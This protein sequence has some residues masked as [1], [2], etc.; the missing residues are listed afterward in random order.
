LTFGRNVFSDNPLI[1][2]EKTQ[3]ELIN[4]SKEHFSIFKDPTDAAVKLHEMFN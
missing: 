3:L 1:A 4:K 2:S